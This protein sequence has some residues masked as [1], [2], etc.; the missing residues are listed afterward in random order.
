MPDVDGTGE[1]EP[2]GQVVVLEDD[3]HDGVYDR[4]TVFLDGLT[5]ARAIA[6][7]EDGVLVAEPPHLWYCRDTD[8][9]LRSDWKIEL[10]RYGSPDPDHLEHTE[11]G[12]LRNLDNWLY[13]AKS[14]RRFRFTLGD[15]GVPRLEEEQSA[16]RGQWGITH[17][18]RGRLFYNGNSSYLYG[19]PWP[20]EYLLRGA[21]CG[22]AVGQPPG[23]GER[24]VHDEGVH[25][26]RVNPGI[27]RGYQKGMLRADGRLA[28]TT[29]VSGGVIYRGDQ[30]PPEFQG[31][32]FIP[33]PA[34]NVVAHFDLKE[35]GGVPRGTQ[36]IYSSEGSPGHAF[37]ASTDERFRPVDCAIGPD[38]ALYIVDLYR[39]V[40]QH[41]QFVT[42]YLRKQILDRGLDK[43]VGLGRIWRVVREDQP[44]DHASPAP[45]F[46]T[47]EACLAAL[48]AQ[49]G[50]VRDAAQ[51]TLIEREDRAALSRVRRVA[52]RGSPL[53]RVHA[54][55]TLEGLGAVDLESVEAGLEFD[56]PRVRIAA[57]RVA[58]RLATTAIARSVVGKLAPL[59]ADP[60]RAVR[61]QCVFSLGEFRD[62]APESVLLA[63]IAAVRGH[64]DDRTIALAAL[65]GWGDQQLQVLERLVD[66][67][68]WPE[69]GT[70]IFA[71]LAASAVLAAKDSE[72][73]GEVIA[74]LLA[75]ADRS[76]DRSP[77]RALRI[78]EGLERIVS[79]KRFPEVSLASTPRIF[80]RE[81]HPAEFTARLNALEKKLRFD[82]T[83][84]PALPALPPL[85]D[86][87]ARRA[88]RG[89]ALFGT[90][91]ICHGPE[92]EGLRGLGP[93]LQGSPRIEHDDEELLKI[94]FDGLTGPL[95]VDGE[96]WNATMPGQRENSVFSDDAVAGLATW[97][98]RQWGHRGAE[99]TPARVAEIRAETAGRLQPWHAGE[100]RGEPTQESVTSLFDGK[101]LRGW[102]RHGGRA[103]YTV[104]ENA[105]V[106]R[107]VPHSP[108]TFLTS[109]RSFGDFELRYEFWVQSSL[110]SGVQI[111]SRVGED[112]VM[113]G[114]QIEID[115]D[116]DR[117]RYWSGG[118]YEEGGR[119]WL[120]DL[121]D[122]DGARMAARSEEWNSVRVVAEG[123]RL[124]TW[125][126]EIPTA[127]LL[128]AE[129]LEGHLGL[130][131]HG[132]GKLEKPLEVRWRNI[133]LI[134]RGRSQFEDSQPSDWIETGTP[135][136]WRREESRWIGTADPVAS[137]APA[138]P[139]ETVRFVATIEGDATLRVLGAEF[140]KAGIA[141]EGMPA[142]APWRK[143]ST[144]SPLDGQTPIVVQ[145]VGD[146][147]VVSVA[148]KRI[149]DVRKV[150][151]P[152]RLAVTG[153]TDTRVVIESLEIINKVIPS[154]SD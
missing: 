130:Q 31:D 111:R 109:D 62:S 97:L 141:I 131:V 20:A 54:L 65:S 63:T 46:E 53:A 81:N 129:A 133:E 10:T 43:P 135:G 96:K 51:R 57:L 122:D 113:R 11:N 15:D 125:I 140:S 69:Q 59:I 120:D 134:E 116:H 19:D 124:R 99:V 49:N 127:D 22:R 106:G 58:E 36:V 95:S 34:G 78:L 110:N 147:V 25:S 132:V 28:R 7:V 5:N 14:S 100:L 41:R 143:A 88:S 40:L 86:V 61:T 102:S 121:A 55:W 37:L 27:N 92:G 48:G 84:I 45:K 35:R 83:D 148:G 30:F 139:I 108:N 52:R 60:D 77:E 105:I 126:R 4:S 153:A 90:C 107:T 144:A 94:I 2:V 149:F 75:L 89:A 70:Q 138:R 6:L 32:A 71:D 23:I 73:E 137:L 67:S 142:A 146:R 72:L 39:G 123:G 101:T 91:S 145:R 79:G 98:R 26:I 80:E 44:I 64:P 114:Y 9:D 85:D 42:S 150:A 21:P 17:D 74:T 82:G 117:K 154:P 104:E 38:G 1:T 47:T 3:D 13:S 68:N 76:L 93:R 151:A 103:N 87:A 8:G 115:V 12:L 24:I 66:D 56:D 112:D 152:P 119:G 136:T 18:D 118:I 33:E 128:D 16:F 50:W 29:S